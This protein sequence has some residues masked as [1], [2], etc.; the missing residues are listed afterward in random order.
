MNDEVLRLKQAKKFSIDYEGI[1]LRLANT[2]DA[3]RMM[4]WRN[5][6]RES[7]FDTAMI[8][9]AGQ[10]QWLERYQSLD[11]DLMFIIERDEPVGQVGLYDITAQGAQ[12]GRLIRGNRKAPKGTMYLACRALL[13]FA[14]YPLN[15]ERVY[16]E[17]FG[18][19]LPAIKLYYKL[20]FR[21]KEV[22]SFG[23]EGNRWV[24]DSDKE[25]EDV[26]LMEIKKSFFR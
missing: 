9:T 1:K 13:W 7:F 18:K 12:F 24:C 3:R 19:N 4:N 15:L 22:V 11:N 23:R 5:I 17:V 16:L 10:R 26:W 21:R 6:Y 8:T 25:A 2:D 14:F 20:G